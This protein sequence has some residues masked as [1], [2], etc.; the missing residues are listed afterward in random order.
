MGCKVKYDKRHNVTEV[1]AN[2]G[3]VSQLWSDL[4]ETGLSNNEAYNYYLI[5][6]T[7][8]FTDYLDT[9]PFERD[10]NGEPTLESIGSIYDELKISKVL[11]D[12]NVTPPQDIK[13][14]NKIKSFLET[15]G[16]DYRS[17]EDVKDSDGKPLNAIGKA[18]MLTKIIEVSEGRADITTLP[19]EAAHFFV[20]ILRTKNPKL[21]N[22]MY[23]SI[24]RYKIYDKVVQE[25]G[26]L[27]SYTGK[28]HKLRD[29][30][31]AKL[32]ANELVN[33][34]LENE[35]IEALPAFKRWFAKLLKAIGRIFDGTFSDPYKAAAY[36]ML[37]AEAQT[38]K[39]AA[40]GITSNEV[41]LQSDSSGAP[42]SQKKSTHQE[43]INCSER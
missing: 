18:D 14:N 24:S 41:Y 21:Y 16:V 27:E 1:Y 31:I 35:N 22:Q 23:K 11:D 25:Y 26:G 28:E 36:K 32:I 2:N 12:L 7:D 40:A 9:R 33:Q 42:N 19:E 3:A 5:S 30:A 17:V 8:E 10:I 39:D 43:T 6:R 13:L 29:E 37:N 38:Y 4:K 20:E 34:H 15:I